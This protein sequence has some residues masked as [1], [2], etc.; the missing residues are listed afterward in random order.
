MTL[1]PII[2]GMPITLDLFRTAERVRRKLWIIS[3]HGPLWIASRH[4]SFPQSHP[5]PLRTNWINSHPTLPITIPKVL[6]AFFSFANFASFLDSEKFFPR[7]R[8]RMPLL[9][10]A[11]SGSSSGSSG[12]ELAVFWVVLWWWPS[13]VVPPRCILNV[14]CI[15]PDVISTCFVPSLSDLVCSAAAR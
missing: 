14:N 9:C 3:R 13:R 12:V 11:E 4:P 2:W 6:A 7:C 8:C 1:E 10:K 15:S 5:W